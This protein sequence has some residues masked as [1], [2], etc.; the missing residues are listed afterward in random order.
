VTYPNPTFASGSPNAVEPPEPGWP[1]DLGPT[2]LIGGQAR[3]N[4]SDM[5]KERSAGMFSSGGQPVHP[6]LGGLDLDR[7]FDGADIE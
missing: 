7:S 6:R 1:N 3:Q 2:I 4:P 5:Q